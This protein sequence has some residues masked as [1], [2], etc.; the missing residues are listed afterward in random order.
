MVAQQACLSLPPALVQPPPL[1][2]K[3]NVIG[4]QPWAAPFVPDFNVSAFPDTSGSVVVQQ[5]PLSLPPASHQPPSLQTFPRAQP[6]CTKR[7]KRDYERTR[8]QNTVH[9]ARQ[10]LHLCNMRLD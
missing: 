7:F 5:A 1:L 4:G 3:D 10:G 6:G 2:C 9:T 8:H